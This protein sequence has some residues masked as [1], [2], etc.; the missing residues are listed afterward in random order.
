VPVE[1]TESPAML[2]SLISASKHFAENV[3]SWNS[4]CDASFA[5]ANQA[6]Q[7]ALNI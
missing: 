6:T 3:R 4:S 5:D 2:G 7:E 1:T